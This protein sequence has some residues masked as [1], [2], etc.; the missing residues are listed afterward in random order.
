MFDLIPWRPVRAVLWDS[1]LSTITRLR[2]SDVLL[3]FFQPPEPRPGVPVFI[4]LPLDIATSKP[5]MAPPLL[6]FALSSLARIDVTGVMVDVWW[7]LCEPSPGKYHFEP[8][9]KLFQQCKDKGLKVQATL[10]FHACGGNVGDSVNIP[11]PDWVVAAGDEYQFWFTDRAGDST[12]EYISFGADH[13]AVLPGP[14]GGSGAAAGLNGTRRAADSVRTP[15]QAYEAYTRA[16]VEEMR[17]N[18]LLGSTV[19]E[20]QVGLGPCGELRYPSYQM[21]RWQFPGIGEFQCFDDFLLKDLRRKIEQE[22]SEEVKMATMPP[23]G[24][25]TYNARPRNTYFFKRGYKSEAGRFFQRWYAERMLKHG[26]DVLKVVRHIVRSERNVALAV[27]VAGIHWWKH[28]PSRAAEA[29]SGYMLGP[30]EHAYGAIARMLKDY[31]AI[32]DFTCLEMRSVD[33]PWLSARCGPRQLVVEVFEAAEKAGVKVAGENALERYD[34]GGFRQ[35]VKAFRRCG[36]E[37]YGFTLL[38]LGDEMMK[39]ENFKRLQKFVA[40][41][42]QGDASMPRR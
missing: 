10:S 34:E 11:L 6:D 31:D 27:K 21:N 25:G 26:E 35:I 38:R 24:T 12:R 18:E 23:E 5:S 20:L 28:S 14:D 32:F 17:K 39:E 13:E 30:G 33:Q 4:M 36:A 22:G 8:Y 41:M 16:F 29:M 40:E 1:F 19:T 9:V 2:G 42:A 15:V 37:R 3:S 7:G